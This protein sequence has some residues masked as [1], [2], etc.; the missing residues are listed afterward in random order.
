LVSFFRVCHFEIGVNI[1][2]S[3]WYKGSAAK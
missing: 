1:A 3:A 2:E